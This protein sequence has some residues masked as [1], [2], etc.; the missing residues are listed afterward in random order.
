MK[1]S[2]SGA[3]AARRRSPRPRRRSSQ[4]GS[5]PA[6]VVQGAFLAH[7]RVAARSPRWRTAPR[8]PS[9]ACPLAARSSPSPL[10]GSV[11]LNSR[12]PSPMNIRT[13]TS[14]RVLVARPAA[15]RAGA[16]APGAVRSRSASSLGR[17]V[18]AEVLEAVPVVGHGAAVR[19]AEALRSPQAARG[20]RSR[21]RNGRAARPTSAPPAA[22]SSRRASETVRSTTVTMPKSRS[23]RMSEA[24]SAAKPAIAVAPEASTAAPVEA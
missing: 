16:P 21:A 24:I 14:P 17:A 2:T 7:V 10:F 3:C 6:C 5:V 1:V 23:I 4:A 20:S 22:P 15:S 9:A 8:T 18:A 12:P 11:W 13:P 19:A